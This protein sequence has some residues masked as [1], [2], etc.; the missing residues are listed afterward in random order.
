MKMKYTAEQLKDLIRLSKEGCNRSNC[1]GCMWEIN[2]T[3]PFTLECAIIQKTRNK[4]NW[5]QGDIPL[6]TVWKARVK[7]L[8]R[9]ML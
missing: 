2:I 1:S 6:S 5:P 9:E 4:V 7:Y 3:K 8:I